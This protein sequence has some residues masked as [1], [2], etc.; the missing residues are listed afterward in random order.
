MFVEL[1]WLAGGCV[2]GGYIVFR[3]MR[4]AL[5]K[6][7]KKRPW[8]EQEKAERVRMLV[9]ATVLSKQKDNPAALQRSKKLRRRLVDDDVRRGEADLAQRELE[10]LDGVEAAKEFREIVEANH[11]QIGNDRSRLM[12]IIEEVSARNGGNA[13]MGWNDNG[14]VFVHPDLDRELARR[15]NEG[16]RDLVVAIGHAAK[17][18]PPGNV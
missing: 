14:E 16:L 18:R 9:E 10:R 4:T 13:C 17:G 7:L 6:D 15:G 2:A 5:L 12:T 8:T 3:G 1:A 11:H